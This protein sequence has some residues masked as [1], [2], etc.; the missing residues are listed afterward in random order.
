MIAD[1]LLEIK[2]AVPT[3]ELSGDF[4]DKFGVFYDVEGNRVSF[5]ALRT[6]ATKR[7]GTMRLIR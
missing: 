1:D 7:S 4:H 3:H 2:L 5:H 6:I